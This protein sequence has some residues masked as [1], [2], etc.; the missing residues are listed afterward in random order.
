MRER[1]WQG[2]YPDRPETPLRIEAAAYQGKPTYFA[3]D[4]AV[5]TAGAGKAKIQVDC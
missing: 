4:R 2:A 5:G 1:A 3:V